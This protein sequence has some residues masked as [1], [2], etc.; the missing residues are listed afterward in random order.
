MMRCN[1][2]TWMQQSK[3]FVA[4]HLLRYCILCGPGG[5]WVVLGVPGGPQQVPGVTRGARGRSRPGS[6][7]SSSN[8][9]SLILFRI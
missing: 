7:G 4:V 3:A 9:N 5:A 1:E 6:L 2:R 8:D